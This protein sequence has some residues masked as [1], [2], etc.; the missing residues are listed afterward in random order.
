MKYIYFIQD[1]SWLKLTLIYPVS[2]HHPSF[3][4]TFTLYYALRAMLHVRPLERRSSRSPGRH[5]DL[6]QKRSS[7]ERYSCKSWHVSAISRPSTQALKREVCLVAR[8]RHTRAVVQSM[9]TCMGVDMM[10]PEKCA[11]LLVEFRP[12]HWRYNV[13][14]DSPPSCRQASTAGS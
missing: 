4:L 7:T 10:I 13:Q 8:S 12:H 11:P 3:P 2:V 5:G 9:E 1:G 6:S 14:D